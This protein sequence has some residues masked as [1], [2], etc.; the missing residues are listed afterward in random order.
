MTYITAEGPSPAVAQFIEAL[1]GKILSEKHWGKRPLVYKI[2]KNREGS[3][4][5]IRFSLD[6]EK[7]MELNRRILLEESVLRHLILVAP[8]IKEAKPLPV[9]TPEKKEEAEP[10]EKEKTVP[11]TPKVKA[12]TT[13]P[14]PEPEPVPE[15]ERQKKLEEELKKILEA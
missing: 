13:K 12:P 2:R 8:A 1:G 6:P 9:T 11:V 3:Y 4:T 7:I 15:T 10:V 5:T 14:K